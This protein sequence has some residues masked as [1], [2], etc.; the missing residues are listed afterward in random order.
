MHWY[1]VCWSVMDLTVKSPSPWIMI[2][3]SGSCL[4]RC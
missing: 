2:L 4:A 3:I 1:T